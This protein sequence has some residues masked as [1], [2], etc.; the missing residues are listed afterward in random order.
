MISVIIPTFNRKNKLLR[1]LSSVMD[2][3]FRDIEIIIIDDGSTDGTENA[4]KSIKD[5]RIIFLKH[6]T[7]IGGGA[8]RNTGIRNAHGDYIAF[9]DSDDVWYKNKLEVELNCLLLNDADIVFCKMNRIVDGESNKIFPDNYSEGFLEKGS[10]VHGIGTPTILGKSEIFRDCLFDEELPRLQELELLIRLSE[11]YRIYC[12][13]KPLMD[14]YFDKSNES[15]SGNPIKLLKASKILHEKYPMLNR[16]FPDT[17]QLIAG[18]L[19]VNSYKNNIDES[20]RKEMRYLAISIDPSIK[21]V[22]KYICTVTG[23]FPLIN[24]RAAALMK[25]R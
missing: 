18:D 2:Q 10:N 23:I 19:I 17:S 13:D 9:Q 15:I 25:E 22:L 5:D 3:T 21:T 12:C 4:I 11:K 24:S 20:S 14:T 7:N 6:K 16:Q 1:S 8:A